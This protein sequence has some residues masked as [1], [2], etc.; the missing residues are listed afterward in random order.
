MFFAENSI[1]TTDFGL[2]DV[3]MNQDKMTK[4]NYSDEGMYCTH[5]YS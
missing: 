3:E 1:V 2:S 5:K 4:V